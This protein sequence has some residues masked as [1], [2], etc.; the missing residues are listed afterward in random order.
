METSAYAQHLG[1]EVAS[2]SSTHGYHEE[3]DAAHDHR[4]RKELHQRNIA[5]ET[6]NAV[7]ET[8]DFIVLND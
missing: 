2:E 8:N 5:E 6:L 3:S 1:N 7:R 4:I